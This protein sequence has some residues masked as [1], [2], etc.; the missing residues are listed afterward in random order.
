MSEKRIENLPF[1]KKVK[2]SDVLSCALV[3]VVGRAA[4]S[5][6]FSWARFSER[7]ACF[8]QGFAK[9]VQSVLRSLLPE[10]EILELYAMSVFPALIIHPLKESTEMESWIEKELLAMTEEATKVLEKVLEAEKGSKNIIQEA[11]EVKEKLLKHLRN[12][13]DRDE[14]DR[15][16]QK[17]K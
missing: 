16:N 14:S 9:G 12:F 4:L 1:Y 3:E 10:E 8:T 11:N 17:G 13:G 7:E 15:E 6:L 5:Q 2:L